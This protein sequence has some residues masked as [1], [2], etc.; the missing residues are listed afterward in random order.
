[1]LGLTCGHFIVLLLC[2]PLVCYAGCP[3][4]RV[5]MGTM[6]KRGRRRNWYIRYTWLPT[7]MSMC[8]VCL[9]VWLGGFDSRM[10]VGCKR[11]K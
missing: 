9:N 8:V 7:V 5:N 2:Q 6:G 10:D 11:R 1:M 3:T 4:V